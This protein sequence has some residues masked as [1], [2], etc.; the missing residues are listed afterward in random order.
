MTTPI[1]SPGPDH[2]VFSHYAR[3]LVEQDLPEDDAVQDEGLVAQ[4]AIPRHRALL[5]E[6]QTTQFVPL[7]V[8]EE[9]KKPQVGIL[10]A[11]A[12]GLYAALILKSLGIP[13]EILEAQHR[14]GGRL[15]T[16][17][18]VKGK[19]DRTLK[20]YEYFVSLR[21]SDAR[22]FSHSDR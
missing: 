8:A 11:G 1:N 21:T 7:H 13:F 12:G 14:T 15:F 16:K 17:H 3:L 2:D 19:D 9:E 22:P 20:E 10:G 5:S 4:A 18:L 6:F